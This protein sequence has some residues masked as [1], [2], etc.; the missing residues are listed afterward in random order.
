MITVDVEMLSPTGE[1]CEFTGVTLT[2]KLEA[3]ATSWASQGWY[4]IM[5]VITFGARGEPHV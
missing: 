4:V 3:Q 2:P 1:R 5:T